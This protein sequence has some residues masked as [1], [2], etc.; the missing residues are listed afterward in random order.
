MKKNIKIYGM[1]ATT[2]L[3]IAPMG[4]QVISAATNRNVESSVSS[5]TTSQTGSIDITVRDAEVTDVMYVGHIKSY[6]DLKGADG[7]DVSGIVSDITSNGLYN[8]KDLT[9][10]FQRHYPNPFYNSVTIK[11][12]SKYFQVNN[13][14]AK[15]ITVNGEHNN[16]VNIDKNKDSITVAQKVEYAK[17]YQDQTLNG[18]I[19]VRNNSAQV[20]NYDDQTGRM[21]ESYGKHFGQD[22]RWLTDY[23]RLMT[24]FP[25]IGDTYYRVST[26]EWL[27]SKDVEFV[28]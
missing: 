2:L 4:T 14:N 28:Y 20:Y 7:T 11:F 24:P 12:N 22:S 6:V 8:D 9:E 19:R 16:I 3:A 17:P 1:V 10:K 21:K 15:Q 13:N 27:N 26:N 18:V 5:K 23:Q 25:S